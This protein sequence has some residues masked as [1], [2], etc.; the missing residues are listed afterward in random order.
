MGGSGFDVACEWGRTAVGVC[1]HQGYSSQSLL[2]WSSHFRRHGVPAA[3][4]AQVRLARVVRTPAL[5][6]SSRSRSIIVHLGRARVEVPAG[7]DPTAL[8]AVLQAL[9]SVTGSER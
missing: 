6:E 5:V 4:N 2:S 8:A 3:S 9:A 1:S 7:A